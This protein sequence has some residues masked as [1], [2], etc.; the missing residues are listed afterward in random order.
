MVHNLKK[1]NFVNSGCS[2]YQWEQSY[3]IPGNNSF[4]HVNGSDKANLSERAEIS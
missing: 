2:Q 1:H 4:S 3:R